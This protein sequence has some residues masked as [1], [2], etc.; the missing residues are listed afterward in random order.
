MAEKKM[1]KGGLS[2]SSFFLVISSI[3]PRISREIIDAIDTMANIMFIILFTLLP[4]VTL[5]VNIGS[6]L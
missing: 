3:H 6:V 2:L 5:A 1:E 4:A